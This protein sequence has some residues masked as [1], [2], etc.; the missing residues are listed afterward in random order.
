LHNAT[1][2]PL[3]PAQLQFQG[4]LHVGKLAVVPFQHKFVVGAV[5]AGIFAALQHTQSISQVIF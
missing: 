4:P 3:I 5:C 1:L 2:H